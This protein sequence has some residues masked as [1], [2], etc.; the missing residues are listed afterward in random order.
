MDVYEDTIHYADQG[1]EVTGIPACG[2]D[3]AQLFATDD[4]SLVTCYDC[5]FLFEVIT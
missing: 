5:A 1:Y 2:V 4:L 3:E